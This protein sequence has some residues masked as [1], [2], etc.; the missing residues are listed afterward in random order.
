MIYPVYVYGTSVLRKKAQEI[1]KNFE[2][3]DIFI[4][5]MFETM[6]TAEGVGLAAPQVGES[7][8]LFIVD[9]SEIDS[10]DEEYVKDFRKVF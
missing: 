10:E 4:E 8:R 1:D 2:G 3:L 6:K 9:A 5:E 7:L